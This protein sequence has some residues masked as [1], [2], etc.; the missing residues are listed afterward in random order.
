[1][2]LP[3]ACRSLVLFLPVYRSSLASPIFRFPVSCILSLHVYSCPAVFLYSLYSG[4]LAYL[5]L[6][7][8]DSYALLS[9]LSLYLSCLI[10]SSGILL[11]C[12]SC[13]VHSSAIYLPCH[14]YLIALLS[15]Y[16]PVALI[17]SL[18]FHSTSPYSQGRISS[19]FLSSHC[20]LFLQLCVFSANLPLLSALPAAGAISVFR[21]STPLFI[22]FSYVF[23]INNLHILPLII[24]CLLS[25]L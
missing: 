8:L 13:L 11:L 10:R 25:F 4:P 21:S 12:L 3:F 18:S 9:P 20:P 16:V 23:S 24:L 15:S 17:S 6:L 5:S 1:M 2:P 22:V 14:S 7:S 19:C